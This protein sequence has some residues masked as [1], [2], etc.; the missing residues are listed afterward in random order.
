MKTWAV[1]GLALLFGSGLVGVPSPAAAE[2]KVGVSGYVKLDIQYS[3]KIIGG[4]FPSP[5]PAGTPLD[6]NAEADNGQTLLDAR[7][8]RFRIDARDEV[9]GVKI[10][11]RIEADFF[12]GDGN[13]VVSNSRH[14]RLRHAFM[15]GDHPS[16][17]FILAGQTWTLFMNIDSAQ[18]NTVDFNGPAGQIFARQPQ[19]RVGYRAPMGPMGDLLL[20]ASVEKHSLGNLGSDAVN[21]SQG[22][23]QDLPAFIGKVSWL[24]KLIKAEAAAAVAKNTVILA[25]GDDEDDTGFGFQ[26]S[27]EIDLSPVTL[28]GHYQFLDG[29]GRLAQADFGTQ[30]VLVGNQLESVESNGFYV[31]A[32]LAL[33][34]DTSVNAAYGWNKLDEF[35]AGGITLETHQSIVVNIL[36]KFWQR[37]QVGIEYRR[38]DVEAFNGTEGD[39]NI[40]HGALWFFF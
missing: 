19:L 21:E 31:G 20:E 8:T 27:A 13:A 14:L 15:R 3:D 39:A 7:Q 9:A 36:H 12:T 4:G 16:G 10:S 40:V 6:T 24:S 11:S 29:L 25:G 5:S 28:F 2:L 35:E 18:P 22:E 23:G 1:L 17:F 26:V 33:T 38:F 37:W 30:V 32:S 34:K